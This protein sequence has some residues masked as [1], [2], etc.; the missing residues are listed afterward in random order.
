MKRREILA[1]VL[2]MRNQMVAVI[3]PLSGILGK[4]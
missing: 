2:L 1:S 4:Q 3:F